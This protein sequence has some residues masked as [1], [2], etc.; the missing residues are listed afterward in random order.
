MSI[1]EINKQAL[2]VVESDEVRFVDDVQG[3]D[4][5]FMLRKG[6]KRQRLVEAMRAA[7]NLLE[8]TH[9]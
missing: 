2:I 1:L 5:G 6:V 4:V 3:V 9:A 8:A 7:A